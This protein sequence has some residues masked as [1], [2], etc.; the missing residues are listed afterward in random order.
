MIINETDLC[1]ELDLT[2]E[3]N[4]ICIQD[5][6]GDFINV[7]REQAA[8]LSEVLKEYSLTGELPE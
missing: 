8:K 7:D 6:W 4:V 5:G 1:H 3:G 2:D